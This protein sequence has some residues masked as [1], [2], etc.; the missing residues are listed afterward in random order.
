[1]TGLRRLLGGVVVL[2]S[3]LGLVIC[4]VGIVG[5]WAVRPKVVRKVEDIDARADSGLQR[6]LAV[7]GHVK[8]ALAKA[9]ADV[10]RVNAE[11]AA[12]GAAPEKNR[13]VR[14][15]IQQ[16]VGPSVS[17]L[18]GRL[19]T[20]S[21]TAVVTASLLRSFQDLPLGSAAVHVNPDDLERATDQ[22]GEISA[23]LRKLQAT[24]GDGDQA[25]DQEIVNA[26]NEVDA[27]L[28]R[29]QTIVDDW[30][31]KLDAAREDLKQLKARFMAWELPAVVMITFVLAWTALGQLSLARRA[32]GWL[33]SPP[34]SS[35]A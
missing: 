13:L 9:R 27:V 29:C 33:R 16:Q 8:E 17:D 3:T 14:R 18:S 1:M 12:A 15:I 2:L 24:V 30:H 35:L 21:D 7:T 20:L 25:S 32:W 26:A 11:S 23:A 5:V 19:A 31:S 22:A 28:R 4:L 6:A 10:G 34:T